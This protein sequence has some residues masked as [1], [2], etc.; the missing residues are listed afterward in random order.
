MA[1]IL[2]VAVRRAVAD[3]LANLP[4]LADVH[5]SYG[6]DAGVSGS[7][8]FTGNARA[9]TD[10][11]GLRAGRN[12]RDEDAEFDLVVN[13]AAEGKSLEESDEQAAEYGRAVEEFVSDRKSNQLGVPGL[14]WIRIESWEMRSGQADYGSASQ[15]VYRVRYRGRVE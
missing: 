11:S 15:I 6:W 8:I 9:T 4:E 10:P 5:V 1:G 13:V 7:Q 2:L 14:Q 12:V 3:G